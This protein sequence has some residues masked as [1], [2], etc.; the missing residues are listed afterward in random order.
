MPSRD[1]AESFMENRPTSIF[2]R[3]RYLRQ[4]PIFRRLNWYDLQKVARKC[5]LTHYGK[6]ELICRQGDPADYLYCVISGRIQAYWLNDQGRKT[7]VEFMRR[8]MHFGIISLLT[9]DRHS[10]SFEALND[11]LLLKIEKSSFHHLLKVVPQLGLAFSQSLSQRLRRRPGKAKTVFEST[12]IS[13]YSPVKGRGASAYAANFALGLH[14]QTGKKVILVTVTA[15]ARRPGV[16][17]AQN[18]SGVWK[19]DPVPLNEIFSDY[20]RLVLKISRGGTP[21]DRLHV[22]F[23]PHDRMTIH[24]ISQFVTSLVVD[25]H[26]VVVDLP[27]EMDEVVLKTLTQSDLV[28]LLT[29]E[30]KEDLK[31]IAEVIDQ[32]Q[33][34]LKEKFSPDRVKVLVNTQKD[35]PVRSFEDLNRELDFAITA[36][37]PLVSSMEL[38]ELFE[39]ED[40]SLCAPGKGSVYTQVVTRQSREIG[41]TLVGLVLGGGAALGIAHIGILKVLEEEKIPIDVVSGSSMGALL[42]ALWT[43]GHS[44][45]DLQQLAREFGDKKGLLSLLDPVF[46]ISGFIGGRAIQRWLKKHLG[47][48]SFY[49]TRI[50]LKILAYD[51]VKRQEIVIQSGRIMEAVQ[52]SIAIPGVIEPVIEQEQVIIDGGVLNPLPTNVLIAQGVHKIIAVNVLQS[53]EDVTRG[54]LAEQQ[55]LREKYKITFLRSPLE[56]V[57]VRMNRILRKALMPNISDI[58]VSTLQASGYVLAEQSGQ[59]A[60]VLIHPDLSGINWYELYRVDELLAR[61]EAAARAALPKIREVLS[62]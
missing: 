18:T 5:Q 26:Y 61:G 58:I 19:V 62:E 52:R 12:I 48:K 8:G 21:F 46:P 10:L 43:T 13:V 57:R 2:Q 22:G 49:D 17:L 44:A 30:I 42:G 29:F 31:L 25:Y 34:G 59:Q 36:R 41:G 14:Q 32:L 9:G 53:P 11:S 3:V 50:P 47:D 20:D 38:T 28:T 35:I 56:F 33:E 24:R 54:Y 23:D 6:G 7:D 55:A 39:T 51:L 45:K 60:D 40:F 15:M 4:T 1:G 27:N 16:P 37:L